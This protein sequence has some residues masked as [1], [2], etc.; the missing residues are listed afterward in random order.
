MHVLITGGACYIGSLL[1][2]LLLQRGHTVTVVDDLLFGGTSLLGYWYHP[3]CR[4]VTAN[5]ADAAA[6][7]PRLCR[8]V[9]A[10]VHLAAMVGFPACQAMGLQVARRYHVEAVH[11][12]FAAAEEAGVPRFVFSSTYSTY[13]LARNGEPVT[14]HAP[15]SPQ[16][17]YAET[18]S[19]AEQYLVER[20]RSARGA[21]GIG[22]FATLCGISPR[23]PSNPTS[24]L[25][26]YLL[27]GWAS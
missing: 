17:L 11:H 2:G 22:R 6:F 5:V 26:S 25:I 15:L 21:P 24:C 23:T 12:V 10:V 9:D 18:K 27:K 1:T 3:C 13:G 7:P 14:G 8:E 4:F 16:S 20:A 19:A